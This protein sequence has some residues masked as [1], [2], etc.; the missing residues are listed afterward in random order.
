[1]GNETPMGNS[2]PRGFP[3]VFVSFSCVGCCSGERAGKKKTL[4]SDETKDQLLQGFVLFD[5]GQ[6]RSPTLWLDKLY[7]QRKSSSCPGRTHMA[8]PAHGFCFQG[9]AAPRLLGEM[10]CLILFVCSRITQLSYS[11]LL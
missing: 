11:T 7:L 2:C 3:E 5:Q 8:L 4:T 1:M 6:N 9:S 10:E